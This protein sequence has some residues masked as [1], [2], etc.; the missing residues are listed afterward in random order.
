M[1]SSVVIEHGE[2]RHEIKLSASAMY[3]LE[4]RSAEWSDDGKPMSILDILQCLKDFSVVRFAELMAETMN[5]GAGA[6]VDETLALMDVV[7]FV[8]A[9]RAFEQATEAAF[10]EFRGEEKNAQGAARSR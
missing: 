7:G 6:T 5:A 2:I 10:P 3:R 9:M 1:L 4:R 8:E